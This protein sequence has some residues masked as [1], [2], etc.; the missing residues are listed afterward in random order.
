ME[1]EIEERWAK[2][3]K[4]VKRSWTV[5]RLNERLTAESGLQTMDQ[6]R[7]FERVSAM[8]LL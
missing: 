2:E 7:R 1:R 4:E 5:M 8:R 6:R 3:V